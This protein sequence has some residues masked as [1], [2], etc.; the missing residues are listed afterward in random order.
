M[1]IQLKTPWLIPLEAIFR[2][3]HWEILIFLQFSILEMK[4]AF[5]LSFYINSNFYRLPQIIDTIN[6]QLW[7]ILPNWK[8][9]TNRFLTANQF[10]LIWE[11]EIELSVY[12]RQLK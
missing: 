5:N 9:G 1:A 3:Q 6:R 4:D 11:F 10:S 12:Q 7:S 2:L 8:T